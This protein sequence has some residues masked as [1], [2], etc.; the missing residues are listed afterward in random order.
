MRIL[1]FVCF[2]LLI[3]GPAQAQRE[4]PAAPTR[5]SETG[6]FSEPERRFASAAQ[7][8]RNAA[9]RRVAAEGY[10]AGDVLAAYDRDSNGRWFRRGEIIV[11]SADARVFD[12][13]V[14]LG[15]IER[16]SA[17]LD[18][19]GA[20][21]VTYTAPETVDMEAAVTTLRAAFPEAAIDLNYVYRAQGQPRQQHQSAQATASTPSVVAAMIDGAISAPPC[22]ASLITRR[23]ASGPAAPTS[24]ADT[25]AAIL[26]RAANVD[27]ITLFAADVIS[28]GPIRSAAADDVARALDWAA[29]G[30]SGVIN[31]SL[32]GP[33]SM[34][35]AL[36]V[37][38][39]VNRGALI[40]AAA[41]N[42]G[43]RADAPFPAALPGVIG[44]TAV[45]HRGRIWRRA[46]RGPHVDFA[47]LGVRVDGDHTGTSFA[48]P[49]V[50]GLLAQHLPQAS[51]RL[52]PLA[53][54]Q[55]ETAARDLG[56]P[57]R[58]P[59][60]GLGLIIEAR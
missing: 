34:T 7:D 47:A 16:R 40:V 36:V 50:A 4:R 46:T 21:I 43:P 56:A 54:R 58:D 5:S 45:D 9:A 22:G 28:A 52:A 1:L 57:G 32:T 55:L 12:T 25:V 2:A 53:L 17:F 15:L 29:V 20:R 41:G 3:S 10:D 27:S 30:G 49:Y 38:A 23:F 24:H 35:L 31:V 26:C 11:A 8:Q 39:V 19:A 60:Y 42:D 6:A 51:P 13:I 59:V 33:E 44:V 14:G 48:A 18:V 37:R